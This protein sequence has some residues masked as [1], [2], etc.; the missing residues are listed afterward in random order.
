MKVLRTGVGATPVPKEPPLKRI[1]VVDDEENIRLVLKTLL[2]KHGYE[3]EVADGAEQALASLDAF[4]PDVLDA[5]GRLD[6]RRL[7]ARV[8]A[9]PEARRRLEAIVH[10]RVRARLRAQVA[11]ARGPYVVVAIPLLVEGGGRVNY[12]W[13]D[14]VLVVAAAPAKQLERLVRRDGID[15]A[16][17]QAMIGAQSTREQRLAAADDVIG[18]DGD[19]A[20][21]HAAVDAMDARYRDLAGVAAH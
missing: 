1:L 10:P 4:G 3:V 8:F 5:Q 16:L 11:Q 19:L 9:D 20:Q 14:R 6:R 13:I 18:N 17:A 15:H 21:L 7:R 2:R 12:P